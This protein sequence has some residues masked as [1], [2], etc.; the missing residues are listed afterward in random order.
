MPNLEQ[1]NCNLIFKNTN[2]AADSNK[3]SCIE[4]QCDQNT[5][6]IQ[7]S[8]WGLKKRKEKVLIIC[9]PNIF[10][11]FHSVSPKSENVNVTLV[12]VIHINH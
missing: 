7:V 11:Y 3:C 8:K 10:C 12:G 2:I 9:E 6:S 5:I 4:R 1:I